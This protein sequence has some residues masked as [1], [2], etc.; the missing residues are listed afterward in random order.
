MAEA[1]RNN[2]V[3]LIGGETAEMPDVLAAGAVDISGTL[4]GVVERPRL[5]PRPGI[6]A[7]HV[8][9]GLASSGLHTNGYSLARKVVSDLELRDPLPG[10][11]GEMLGEAL[12]AV[13]RSYLAPLAAALDAELVDGL[14]HIT[15]GGLIDNVPR[16][17]PDGCGAIIDR[18][19]WTI[20]PLFRFL[21]TRSGLGPVESLNILNCGIGMVCVVA[22]AKVDALRASIPEATWIIGEVTEGDGVRIA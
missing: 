16:I 2:G 13:H 10:G 5:L 12:L 1:C 19:S 7:G 9:V 11:D 14:A 20:P 3:V 21:I 8:L 6:A 4:V 15:G 17:L 22:P 18:A